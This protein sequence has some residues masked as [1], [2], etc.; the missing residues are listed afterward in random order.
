MI[1]WLL[2][3]TWLCGQFEGK[4][5][6]KKITP[7]VTRF[8]T[9]FFPFTK[10]Q[11]IIYKTFYD[12]LCCQPLHSLSTHA[13]TTFIHKTIRLPESWEGMNDGFYHEHPDVLDGTFQMIGFLVLSTATEVWVLAGTTSVTIHRTGNLHR[14]RKMWVRA[15]L[16]DEDSATC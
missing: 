2:V 10:F 15:S 5:N 3:D 16:E 12:V 14:Q 6:L 7:L 4:Y 8:V 13:Q 1:T 9:S 11:K